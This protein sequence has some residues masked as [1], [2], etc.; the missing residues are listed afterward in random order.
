MRCM[1]EGLL[2]PAACVVMICIISD[3]VFCVPMF[4]PDYP[5]VYSIQFVVNVHVNTYVC[6]DIAHDELLLNPC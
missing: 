6:I 4:L 5:W 3:S 1:R 2:R